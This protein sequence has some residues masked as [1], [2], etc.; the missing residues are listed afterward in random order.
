[1][2]EW[3]TLGLFAAEDSTDLEQTLASM[4]LRVWRKDEVTPLGRHSNDP[5]PG[6]TAV[7]LA[8]DE[9][10]TTFLLTV[11]PAANG[12]T[13]DALTQREAER[14]REL[15]DEGQLIRLWTLPGHGRNL[16]HWQ[17]ADAQGLQASL[18]SLPMAEWLRIETVPLT[19]HP[20]DPAATA[21]A[22]PTD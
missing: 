13:V 6:R 8:E 17:A 15:A 2:G 14:T 19:R 1:P 3:R 11:P 16:G 18:Q 4:P 5:G 12:A 10:F 7:D 22:D 20:S 9:F 21:G